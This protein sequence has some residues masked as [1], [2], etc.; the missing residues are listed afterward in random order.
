MSCKYGENKSDD[1][2]VLSLFMVHNRHLLILGRETRISGIFSEVS[3]LFFGP[4]PAA[5]LSCI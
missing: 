2:K 4:T 1:R 5:S 3:E